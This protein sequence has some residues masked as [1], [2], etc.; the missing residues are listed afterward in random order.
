MFNLHQASL[1]LHV[2]LEEPLLIIISCYT[3]R[4]PISYCSI[5]DQKLLFCYK[6]YCLPIYKKWFG[7]SMFFL[8]PHNVP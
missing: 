2:I 8:L 6:M 1:L 7:N 5:N 3:G 4:I